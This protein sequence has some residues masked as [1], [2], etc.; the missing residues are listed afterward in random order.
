MTTETA[1]DIDISREFLTRSLV[2]ATSR[3]SRRRGGGIVAP[4][5]R[6]RGP[7]VNRARAG[8]HALILPRTQRSTADRVC[9][10]LQPA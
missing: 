4:A 5:I 2:P 7:F 9:A 10:E 1:Q 8:V 6:P 3:G